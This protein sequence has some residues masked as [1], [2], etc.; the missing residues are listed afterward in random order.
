MDIHSVTKIVGKLWRFDRG[1]DNK[2]VHV[3]NYR[4][5]CSKREKSVVWA[6]AKAS[7]SQPLLS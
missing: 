1:P 7:E 6:G 2:K 3:L 5:D 4:F